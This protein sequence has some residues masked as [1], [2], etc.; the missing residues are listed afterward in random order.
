MSENT[1]A[2]KLAPSLSFPVRIGIIPGPLERI[3]LPP[4]QYLIL[5][6]N[7]LQS[8]FEYQF[9]PSPNNDPFFTFLRSEPDSD[10]VAAEAPGFLIRYKESLRHIAKGYRL[11]EEPAENYV[12]LS[13][14]RLSDNYYTV[15]VEDLSVVALG[16]WRRAM[17][18]PS[19]I[20]FFVFLILQLSVGLS[21][22]PMR[23][24][25]HLGTK[26]CLW[27]F[28]PNLNEARYQI[29]NG[30]ICAHCRR[31]LDEAGLQDLRSDIECVARREWLGAT[32]ESR[33]PANIAAKL[34]H[35]L[36]ITRGLRPTLWE[37]ALSTVRDEGVKQVMK[38]L[39]AVLLAAV[40]VWL[41]LKT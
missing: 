8:S 10:R 18:P 17:A 15:V 3:K 38:I 6:L 35:D 23:P 1:H 28:T 16:N 25:F 30:F 22:P 29:L 2:A 24:A 20:E 32:D 9:Y 39:G 41:G 13:T 5:H 12:L 11:T 37:N 21:F 4:L 34:G 14:V 31:K 26:G 7:T 27:D 36:F 33:S 19:A 40:L